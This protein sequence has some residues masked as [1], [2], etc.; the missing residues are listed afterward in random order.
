MASFKSP[1]RNPRWT[2]DRLRHR[3]RSVS[4]RVEWRYRLRE[5]LWWA[6]VCAVAMAQLSC[7]SRFSQILT[8]WIF[9]AFPRVEGGAGRNATGPRRLSKI[10]TEAPSNEE[11]NDE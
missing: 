3:F 1:D 6:T 7:G 10:N 5:G 11:A 2:P 4:R 8:A 9:P